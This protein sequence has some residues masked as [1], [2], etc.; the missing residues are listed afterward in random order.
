[1]ESTSRETG[2]LP[3]RSGPPPSTTPTNPHQQLDQNAPAELQEKL[4][5]RTRTLP[6]V[7]EGPSGISVPGARAFLLEEA[8]GPPEA[9]LIG[10][11]F[12]HL[13]PRYDGSL[14][15]TLPPD[16]A[17]EA[18]EKGWGKPHPLAGKY[19]VPSTVVMIYGPRNEEE[20]EV[21]WGIVRASYD[22]AR[23]ERR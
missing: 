1:M 13:H 14:H 12:A 22:F 23:G 10:K 5:E 2:G 3:V 21:V 9:F 7:V 15:L 8:G 18:L 11:E 17:A 4:Y 20:L 19:G 6:G 16:L